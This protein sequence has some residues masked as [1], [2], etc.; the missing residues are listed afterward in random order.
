[1]LSSVREYELTLAVKF[2]LQNAFQGPLHLFGKLLYRH[3][4]TVS[5]ATDQD[6]IT[7]EQFVSASREILNMDDGRQIVR[8]YF[9]FFAEGKD[10]MA[11]DGEKVICGKECCVM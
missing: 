11:I 10:F 3:M 4:V 9:H 7:Q 5:S 8:Y 1:M 6:K 2:H